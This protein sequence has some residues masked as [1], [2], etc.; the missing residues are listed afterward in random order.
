MPDNTRDDPAQRVQ[1][2][3][4]YW[5]R[6]ADRAG[7]ETPAP[8]GTQSFLAR[9]DRSETPRETRSGGL[10]NTLAEG[11]RNYEQ[12]RRKHGAETREAPARQRSLR[13]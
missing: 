12:S 11:Q 6:V 10:W 3:S 4:E 8:K 9:S 13:L 2:P 5:R 7:G 1:G